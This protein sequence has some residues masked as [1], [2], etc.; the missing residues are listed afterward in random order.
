MLLTTV[1]ECCSDDGE[2][3]RTDWVVSREQSRQFN[4]QPAA[5][6]AVRLPG[7]EELNDAKKLCRCL[8]PSN[9]RADV[10]FLPYVVAI[11]AIVCSPDQTSEMQRKLRS[12]HKEQDETSD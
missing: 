4:R 5:G 11:F 3:F 2:E 12:R 7:L 10:R 9:M 8:L 6:G 1:E